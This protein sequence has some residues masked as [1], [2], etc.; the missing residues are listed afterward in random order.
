MQRLAVNIPEFDP[1][2]LSSEIDQKILVETIEK[3]I[4]NI[5]DELE[6]L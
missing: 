4:K 5:R 1:S 3:S 2:M 6:K